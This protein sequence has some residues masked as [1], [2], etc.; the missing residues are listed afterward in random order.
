M[1]V[2]VEDRDL[3]D[4]A[5]VQRLGGRGGVVEV[6]VAS[7]PARAGVVAGRPAQRVAEAGSRD[8]PLG[9][10]DRCAD[11][12]AG[13]CDGRG[14]DGG[15]GLQARFGELGQQYGVASADAPEG[16][17]VVGLVQAA[18][19]QLDLL[20][21]GVGGMGAH[22]AVAQQPGLHLGEPASIV[23]AGRAAA[24]HVED[25]RHRAA[26]LAALL[27]HRQLRSAAHSRVRR[28]RE[29]SSWKPLPR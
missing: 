22:A 21:A 3:P 10:R 4:P 17:Q 13:G 25:P 16:L 20:G 1:Q 18:K 6:A 26:A 5:L 7:Q 12:L 11:A 9:G 28:I 29:P 23:V 8:D 19:R 24:T 15:V 27:D 14:A 2:E